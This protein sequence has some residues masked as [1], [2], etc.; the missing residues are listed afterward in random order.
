MAALAPHLPSPGLVRSKSDEELVRRFRAGDEQAFDEL[1]ARHRR[2]LERFAARLVGDRAEDVVQEVLVKAHRALRADDRD[3]ALR[4]WLFRLT[5][6]R[7]LDDLRSRRDVVALDDVREAAAAPDADPHTTLT[8][9]ARLQEVVADIATLPERQREVLLRR[10]VEGQ[11]H[12]EV[13]AQL[14][15][16]V[17]ASKNLVNRAREN[18]ARCEEARTASCAQVR[19][20]LLAATE[21]RTRASA[22]AL[23]HVATCT[24]CRGFRASLG[25]QRRALRLLDPSPFLLPVLGAVGGWSALGAGA[26]A[27][28]SVKVGATAA[29]TAAVAGGAFELAHSVALPGE[30]A[31]VTVAS[32]VLATPLQPESKVPAG[33]AVITQRATLAAG[34]TRHPSIELQCPEGMRVAGMTPPNGAKVGYGYAS[35][36]IVGFSKSARIVFERRRLAADTGIAVGTLCKRPDAAGS[37]LAAPVGLAAARRTQKVCASR[38]YLYETPGQ[39]VVGTVFRSQPVVVRKRTR[40]GAWSRVLTDAGVTGWVRTKALCRK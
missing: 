6:N 33:T 23:R 35:S 7:C 9:R 28:T 1:V 8:R 25:S 21:R 14:G 40:S 10:E 19:G 20:D 22:G 31:G 3:M 39:F 30:R 36:T 16:T 13:A 38:A 26:A 2:A 17:R 29:V 5:R 24:D 15:I 12:E 11:T 27:T 37:L 32:A 34:T 18:L 4:A